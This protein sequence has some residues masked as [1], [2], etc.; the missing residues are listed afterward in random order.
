MLTSRALLYSS[1]T[2]GSDPQRIPQYGSLAA[3]AGNNPPSATAA[4][5]AATRAINLRMVPPLLHVSDPSARRRLREVSGLHDEH[6][7][8]AYWISQGPKGL[9][10][11]P[12]HSVS[13]TYGAASATPC[14]RRGSSPVD[15][16][17]TERPGA[18]AFRCHHRRL[19]SIEWRIWR[20][21][22]QQLRWPPTNI[23]DT[24]DEAL[25]RF[26]M[27]SGPGTAIPNS[28]GM[29]VAPGGIGFLE[30]AAQYA[31]RAESPDPCDALDALT[32]LGEGRTAKAD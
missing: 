17:L 30:R 23:A 32:G 24:P 9:N 26:F 11:S 18:V 20:P 2:S 21:D 8:A 22:L 6:T 27:L 10:S 29:E 7:S 3:A 19:R 28:A 25:S 16:T 4:T 1:S 5:T 13:F 15:V 14:G 12:L 31:D